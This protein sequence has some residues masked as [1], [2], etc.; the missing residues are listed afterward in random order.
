V[1]TLSES[2][3]ASRELVVFRVRRDTRCAECEAELGRGELLRVESQRAL[4]LACADLDHLDFL[5][6]GD[7][8]LTRR[9]R[10]H[11][12]LQ[13]V[14][15]E[16]SRTRQRYERQGLLVESDAL[17]RAEI[18]C[19]SDAEVRARRRE[20]A[21][22]R[23]EDEDIAYVAAFASSI[24]EMFSK[25]PADEATQIAAHACQRYSGRVGRTAAAKAFDGEAVRLA[26]GAHVRHMHTPYDRLLAQFG[27]R[28]LARD[29]VR[30]QV[31]E[32]LSA[33]RQA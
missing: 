6:R 31:E 11:S 21:A 13:A 9:A 29:Q 24:R 5:P 33:W 8:A 12:T 23:R 19:L 28:L 1:N 25:C 27:D 10:A 16:W 32:I 26:V 3:D 17:A 22:A 15:V 4:C 20:R 18:E 7:A 2:A 30:D 14:V